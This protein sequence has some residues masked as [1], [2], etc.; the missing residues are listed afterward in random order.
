MSQRAVV[1][2]FRLFSLERRD[3]CPMERGSIERERCLKKWQARNRFVVSAW[4]Q[5]CGR[6]IISL[7]ALYRCPGI[8][9]RF[10][11]PF[12]R[13]DT[14]D[15]FELR[16]GRMRSNFNSRE[17]V[18][19]ERLTCVGGIITTVTIVRRD[20]EFGLDHG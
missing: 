20:W 19:N 1:S 2:G 7:I 15:E 5:Q 12:V 17:F 14:K 11:T 10:D 8:Y 3:R 9:A 6:N 18:Q 4:A 16:L 13:R